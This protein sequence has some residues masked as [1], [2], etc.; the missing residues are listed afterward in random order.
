MKRLSYIEEARCLKVN[1]Q[2]YKAQHKIIDA[3]TKQLH[4]LWSYNLKTLV[5]SYGYGQ[6]WVLAFILEF[7]LSSTLGIAAKCL[8][9]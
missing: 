3:V 2:I 1:E 7:I 6:L 4:K 5:S 8:C 9:E